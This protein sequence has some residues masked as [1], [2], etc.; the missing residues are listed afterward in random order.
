MLAVAVLALTQL[1]AGQFTFLQVT[2]RS[3]WQSAAA[4]VSTA[5]E[6]PESRASRFWPFAAGASGYAVLSSAV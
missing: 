3:R 2:S 5:E 6:L 4:G 1:S